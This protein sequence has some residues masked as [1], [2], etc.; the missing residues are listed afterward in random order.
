MRRIRR[1]MQRPNVYLMRRGD[2][3]SADWC[4]RSNQSGR[5]KILFG[6]SEDEFEQI[7]QAGLLLE[8]RQEAGY[9]WNEAGF[10]DVNIANEAKE[11]I[12]SFSRVPSLKSG[13]GYLVSQAVNGK[14]PLDARMINAAQNYITD[15]EMSMS[16]AGQVMNWDRVAQVQSRR[17]GAHHAGVHGGGMQAKMRLKQLQTC[18]PKE[19]LAL[20]DAAC[21]A[22]Y[23][24][25]RIELKFDLPTRNAGKNLANALDNLARAYEMELAGG[26]R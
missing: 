2:E 5:W 10:A 12:N 11:N 23:S 3:K 20:I 25:S 15:V 16:V 19:E 14:G 17:R 24:L 26:R 8:G 1:A 18:L 21:L 22:H 13:F 7:L 6:V 4:L 9:Q